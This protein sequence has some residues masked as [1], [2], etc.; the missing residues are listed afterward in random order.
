[1]ALGGTVTGTVGFRRSW[2]IVP[3]SNTTTAIQAIVITVVRRCWRCLTVQNTSS[4]PGAR[5]SSEASREYSAS[6]RRITWS[7]WLGS[8]MKRRPLPVRGQRRAQ[9]GPAAVQPRLDGA[10]RHLAFGRDLADRQL[11]HIVQDDRP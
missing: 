8:V 10:L 11:S 2:T 9:P 3:R 4:A 1:D 7:N 6:R 5:T